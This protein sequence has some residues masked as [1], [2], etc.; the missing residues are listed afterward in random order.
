MI[1][2][3]LK[4]G[5]EYIELIKLLKALNLVYS[6]AEAKQMV[7]EGHVKLN[8]E[9]E[10]R[11]RAKVRVGDIVHFSEYEIKVIK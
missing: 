9:V 6:G 2:F 11:K 8:G 4:E 3:E 7:D 10:G 1:E 5:S